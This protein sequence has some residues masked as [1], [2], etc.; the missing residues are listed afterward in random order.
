MEFI[1]KIE[2]LKRLS[3]SANGNPR[4]EVTFT[5]GTV[6][7]TGK[8]SMVGYVIDNWE[9]RDVMVTVQLSRGKIV[10]IRR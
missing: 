3:N 2:S 4:W 6:F 9:Y 7:E 10:N 8:D 5:D 1:G